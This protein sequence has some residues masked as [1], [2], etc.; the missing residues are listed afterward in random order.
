MKI[1]ILSEMAAIKYAKTTKVSTSIISIT[2]TL[3]D[4]VVFEYNKN[5]KNIFRMKFNDVLDDNSDFAHPKQS[6]F[7]GLKNFIDNLDCELLIVH[8]FAGVS[9][10]AAV[11]A[12]IFKYFKSNINLFEHKDYEP[13]VL[14]YN[15][16]CK[17]LNIK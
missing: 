16:A 14:V 4:D 11:A 13:N 8:C 6:D 12:A 5:I 17:E 10:S 2:S 9:R 1:L 7:N 3:E 15:L